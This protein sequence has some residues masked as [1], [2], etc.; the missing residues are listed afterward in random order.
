M[1]HPPST[2][3]APD[4]F[5]N[6]TLAARG[7][8][9]DALAG[10]TPPTLDQQALA[11]LGPDAAGRLCADPACPDLLAGH[12]PRHPAGPP[13]P[14]APPGST[15]GVPARFGRFRVLCELG[16]GGHGVVF[17]AFDPVLNRQVALKVPRLEMLLT[18]EMR[19]RF[20]REAQA[21]AGLDHPGIVP[22][23]EAGEADSVCY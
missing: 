6:Q 16:R 18:R 13:D 21:A 11:A 23:Y 10:G 17:L 7:G 2:P 14:A 20:L 4:D 3:G 9:P 12:W 22:V 5:R 8:S 19:Q 1:P 15:P